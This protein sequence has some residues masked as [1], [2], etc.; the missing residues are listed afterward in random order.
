MTLKSF[1]LIK[2]I[3]LTNVENYFFI[4]IESG[5]YFQNETFRLLSLIYWTYKL[6]YI[7]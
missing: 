2:E 4:R 5:S 3:I 1:T 7:Q 6:A